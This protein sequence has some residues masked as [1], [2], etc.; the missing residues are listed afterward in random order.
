MSQN[1]RLT[2]EEI[3]EDKF[4]NLVLG[5][6]AFFKDNLRTIIITLAVAL[7][8]IV[9]YLTYTQNQENKYVEASVNF[10]KAA[11]T[12]KEAETN[13]FDVSSATDPEEDPE[14]E[15]SEEKAS[16]QNAEEALQTVFDNYGNTKF[17]DKA[18]FS[19]AKS[20]YFQGQY[21]EAREQFE[22]VIETSRPENQI[23][24]L[25]AHKAIGNCYE[26]EGDYAKAI[27]TYDAKAFPDTPQLSPEIRQYVL[28]N[29]KY[30]QAL[31]HEKLNAVEDA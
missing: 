29:A 25:Y 27:T 10:N 8:G 16:F 3:Q 19:Y 30:N 14:D 6:Y 15:P 28:S 21:A 18:R 13:F 31:C 26:Q 11:E 12:Y 22:Q 9:A 17:A 5:S 2:K 23:Y 7:I 24:A 20:L 4:I 1:K